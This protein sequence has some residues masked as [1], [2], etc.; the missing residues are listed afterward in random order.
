MS[1]S[2]HPVHDATSSFGLPA[3]A[4]R[5]L[6]EQLATAKHVL[7]YSGS[8][9]SSDAGLP[10]YRGEH[11]PE[12]DDETVRKIGTLSG[13]RENIQEAQR[14]HDKQSMRVFR[15]RP[16]GGHTALVQA[17]REWN[18]RHITQNIDLLLENAG[19]KH[20]LHLHGRFDESSCLACGK[21]QRRAQP[22]LLR[23]FACQHC[24]Q[25]ALR[26]G[27]LLMG[28]APCPKAW[29]MARDWVQQAD[30][31]MVIGTPAEMYPGAALVEACH[32]RGAPVLVVNP[33]W[34]ENLHYARWQL[35]AVQRRSCLPCGAMHCA[36]AKL[37][38]SSVGEPAGCPTG[39]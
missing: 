22:P 27:V 7:V 24:K 21:A 33:Q 1:S 34:C 5:D 17:Q 26:P 6:L 36:R 31:V 19:A 2:R 23:G 9:M 35:W 30:L 10:T 28:E 13:F 3:G 25:E 37:V 15:A 12:W 16:H 38:A 11:A 14:W 8:G 32:Q 39:W 29:T 20:V 4:Y 18:I